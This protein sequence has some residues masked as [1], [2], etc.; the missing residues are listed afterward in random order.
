MI[1]IG[2]MGRKIRRF[3]TPQINLIRSPKIRI[4]AKVR[5]SCSGSSRGYIRRT[6]KRSRTTPR[7]NITPV[8]R[9]I[10]GRI[11]RAWLPRV[12]TKACMNE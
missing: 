6:M 2:S 9:T 8:A 4:R 5:S 10:A 12:L 7:R 3:S 11:A 1:S